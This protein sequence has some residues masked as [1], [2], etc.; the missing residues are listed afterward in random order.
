[1]NERDVKSYIFSFVILFL[2]IKKSFIHE[3]VKKKNIWQKKNLKTTHASV[4]P[5]R[6]RP[7]R[8]A[9]LPPQSVC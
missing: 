3:T 1:M 8:A 6:A 7:S 5:G 4:K 2:C 9:C